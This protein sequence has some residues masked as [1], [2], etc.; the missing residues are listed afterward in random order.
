MDP[1]DPWVPLLLV[2]DHGPLWRERLD[3]SLVDDVLR[4]AVTP[5]WTVGL[6]LPWAAAGL[7]RHGRVALA[8]DL[9]VVGGDDLPETRHCPVGHLDCLPV[10]Q[11]VA[12]V[13]LGEATVQYGQELFFINIYIKVFG[14]VDND[15]YYKRLYAMYM[16]VSKKIIQL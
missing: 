14:K 2:L 10:Q 15:E 6:V 1:R 12:G 13:I 7:L 3:L 16:K 4:K 5:K 11:L 8:D 9:A